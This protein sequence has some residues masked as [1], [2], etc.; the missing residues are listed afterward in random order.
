MQYDCGHCGERRGNIPRDESTSATIF[1][2][3]R[4]CAT[5]RKDKNLQGEDA[6]K[7]FGKKNSVNRRKT[8]P[9][10]ANQAE[11]QVRDL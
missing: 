8:L 4:T 5:R 6:E 9:V 7:M 1:D 10:D 11:T 3:F 2:S